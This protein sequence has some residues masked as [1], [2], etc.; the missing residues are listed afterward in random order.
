MA[1]DVYQAVTDRIVELLEQGPSHGASRTG[2]ARA[3]GP[4]TSRATGTTGA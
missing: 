2:A 1:F 3:A 4:G